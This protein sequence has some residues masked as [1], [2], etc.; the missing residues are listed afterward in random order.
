MG[1]E[2]HLKAVTF[3]VPRGA[4]SINTAYLRRN[5]ATWT[6]GSPLMYMSPKAKDFKEAVFD[7]AFS[8]AK[9]NHWPQPQRVKNVAVQI[10]CFGSRV[11]VDGP[12]KF[13]LDAMEGAFYDN[14][15]VVSRVSIEKIPSAVQKME[16]TVS[17]VA[18]V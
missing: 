9:R 11:D 15:K 14:D 5:K 8:A 7:H 6:P 16:I 12:I 18:Q 4:I 3:T 17:L 1:G 10:L 2:V 13:I